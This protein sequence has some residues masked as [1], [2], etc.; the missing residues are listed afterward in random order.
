MKIPY[1]KIPIADVAAYLAPFNE[2]FKG[3]V[4]QAVLDFGLYQKWAD[5]ECSER[6][7]VGYTAVKEIVENEI[8]S[9]K[10][11]CKEQKQKIKKSIKS[12]NLHIFAFDFKLRC[13]NV[14]SQLVLN[15]KNAHLTTFHQNQV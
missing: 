11:F 13:T 1:I 6:E 2:A 7:Q 14:L 10:K 5:L 15:T 12:I 9:Y 8:K 3:R 4:F